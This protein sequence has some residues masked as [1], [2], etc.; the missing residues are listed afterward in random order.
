MLLRGT[1]C[2]QHMLI[3]LHFTIF[4]RFYRNRI[5]RFYDFTIIIGFR[6][7]NSGLLR[8]S[9]H[10]FLLLR[11]AC[12]TDQGRSPKQRQSQQIRKFK[13]GLGLIFVHHVESVFQVS[14]KKGIG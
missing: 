12:R 1:C 8:L 11:K 10:N 13:P 7:R 9:D 6:F 4:I 14:K 3:H 5:F 2:Y